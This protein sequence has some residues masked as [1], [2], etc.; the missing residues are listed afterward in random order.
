[1]R[2]EHEQAIRVTWERIGPVADD[3]VACFYGRLFEVNPG[4]RVLFVHAD[5]AAMRGK[6]LEML[7]EIIRLVDDPDRLVSVVAPLGRRHAGYGVR[8]ED[9][10]AAGGALVWALHATLGEQFTEEMAES[11]RELFHL[12]SGVMVRAG[13]LPVPYPP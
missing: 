2:R 4:A 9:Y 13:Q 11:W 8:R 5:S 12:L 1:M 7:E 3:L 10:A 6:F